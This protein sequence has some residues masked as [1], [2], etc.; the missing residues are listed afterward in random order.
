MANLGALS[1]RSAVIA[2]LVAVGVPALAADCAALDR[3]IMQTDVGA[4]E[5][6]ALASISGAD[7]DGK[8]G[9]SLALSGARSVHCAWPFA[10]R[11]QAATQTFV[12]VSELLSRCLDADSPAS[13]DQI[14]NHPDSYD[15]RVFVTD[16]VTVSVSLKDKGA[17][18]Q[19]FVFLRAE[20]PPA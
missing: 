14:V 13:D 10:Y 5:P 9:T 17:L 11:A 8:C 19:T 6:F 2:G 3:W 1:Q 20:R 4:V 15:L 16:Q 7:I 12:Q 18:Q